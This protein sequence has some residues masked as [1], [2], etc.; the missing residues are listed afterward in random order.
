MSSTTGDSKPIARPPQLYKIPTHATYQV[1][2]PPTSASTSTLKGP[3]LSHTQ[4]P[5]LLNRK[6]PL[7]LELATKDT[8]HS[9]LLF[10]QPSITSPATAG[11]H[12][13]LSPYGLNT[14]SPSSSRRASGSTTQLAIPTS[15][16]QHKSLTEI[17]V[18]TSEQYRSLKHFC[19]DKPIAFDDNETWES[20]LCG[21]KFPVI[22]PG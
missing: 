3:T 16:V 1:T 6:V 2:S 11:L 13:F 19:S 17:T 12:P 5:S 10:P 22:D 4:T 9:T 8:D 15:I 14:T 18:F 7:P 21:Q 20:I